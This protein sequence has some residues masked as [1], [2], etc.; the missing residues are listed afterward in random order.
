MNKKDKKDK[1]KKR[2]MVA[3]WSS[4]DPLSSESES[5]IEIKANIC[6]MAI[7]EEVCLDDFNDFDKLQN[8]YEC[9]FDDF[10]ILRHT[11]K[12][13]KKIITNL[14]LDIEKTKLDYDVVMDNK[15]KLEKCFDNLKSENEVL[16]LELEEK[17]KV[18]GNCLKENAALK[19][20]KNRNEKHVNH[21]H[22]NRSHRKKHEHISCYECGR[23]CHI[24]FYCSFNVKHPFVKKIWVPKGSHILTNP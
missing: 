14:T 5:E 16:R 3:T 20:S 23:K 24:A 8:E 13:Y 15:N 19:I 1:K 22:A 21:M 2:V 6:L 18:L 12:D 11:C 7:Y 4:S 9:L 17:S 10:E